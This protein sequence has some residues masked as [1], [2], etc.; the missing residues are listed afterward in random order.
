MRAYIFAVETDPVGGSQS[1]D[2]HS[3]VGL[4][5]WICDADQLCLFLQTA[6]LGFIPAHV[7]MDHMVAPV[8]VLREVQGGRVVI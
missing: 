5:E 7:S 2:Q 8:S 6:T 4:M 3:E 1:V